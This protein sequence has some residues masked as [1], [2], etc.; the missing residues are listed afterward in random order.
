[1]SIRNANGFSKPSDGVHK[2]K[3]EERMNF[4]SQA[5]ASDSQLLYRAVLGVTGRQYPAG[6]KN[7]SPSFFN[8]VQKKRNTTH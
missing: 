5:D 1:M 8:A 4:S 7:S 3:K 6:G 2:K